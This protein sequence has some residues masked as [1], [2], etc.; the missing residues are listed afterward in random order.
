M[1]QTKT[2]PE[3]EPPKIDLTGLLGS[4]YVFDAG[5]DPALQAQLIDA[6]GNKMGAEG[7]CCGP[8]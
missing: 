7:C 5:G 6:N 4:G 8:G 1:D 3:A 2:S